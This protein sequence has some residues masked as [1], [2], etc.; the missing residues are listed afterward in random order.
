M[1]VRI[2]YSEVGNSPDV[3][4]AIPTYALV[5]GVPVTQSDVLTPI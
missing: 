3:F 1:K 4:L 5:D 2:S